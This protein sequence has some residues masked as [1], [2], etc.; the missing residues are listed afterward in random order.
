MVIPRKINYEYTQDSN[1]LIIKCSHDGYKENYKKIVKR[2][3]IISK[4]KNFLIGQ[5]TITPIKLNSKKILYNI[6][7]HL[8]PHCQAQLTN[9]KKKVR[10]TKRNSGKID[11]RVFYNTFKKCTC[12][13]LVGW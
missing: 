8:M 1:N 12:Y 3:L 7:F 5:D 9:S 6:R 4:M 10:R 11:G 2:K 13:R